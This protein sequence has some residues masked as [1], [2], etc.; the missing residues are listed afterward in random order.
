MW[1]AGDPLQRSVVGHLCS[2]LH[3]LLWDCDALG[4]LVLS[5]F[6]DAR[7]KRLVSD[8][9]RKDLEAV[10]NFLFSISRRSFC[11]F[12]DGVDE[13][14][15]QTALIKLVQRPCNIER[16]RVC[17]SS[18]PEPVLRKYF[19]SYPFLYMQDLTAQDIQW[20]TKDILRCS[21]LHLDGQLD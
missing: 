8:W 11:L 7:R 1:A 10:L 17:L 15:D 6:K 9:S 4:S 13:A 18:R 16:V 12:L 19:Q 2:L 5:H 20:Y 3:Q 14:E 21:S